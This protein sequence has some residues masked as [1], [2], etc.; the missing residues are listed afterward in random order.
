MD[1]SP[2]AKEEHEAAASFLALPESVLV[3]ILEKL[4]Q[5]DRLSRAALACKAWAAAAAAATTVITLTR[6]SAATAAKF[7]SWLQ[8]HGG[9][10]EAIT[11]PQ[12]HDDRVH[13]HMHVPVP[14]Q[15]KLPA[16]GLAKLKLL[17]LHKCALEFCTNASSSGVQ[18]GSSS[19]GQD[20][21]SFVL[22]ALRSIQLQ[23]CREPLGIMSQLGCPRLKSLHLTFS[24]G[25]HAPP[26]DSK[27]LP[28]AALS[29]LLQRLPELMSLTLANH[30]VTDAALAQLSCLQNLQH[31]TLSCEQ[32][33]PA[34]LT[35]LSSS[36]L[37]SF[38]LISGE[39]VLQE[40]DLPAA[41]WPH[42]KLFRVT[43]HAVQPAVVARLTALERL[44][45]DRC[46]L[47]ASLNTV[48]GCRV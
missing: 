32:V 44:H 48:S 17:H 1:C 25:S 12:T 8:Q 42:L 13:A 2:A 26:A 31:C 35:N 15:L 9:V 36:S 3:N 22:P 43:D 40:R 10:V 28:D 45:L 34:V 24:D 37:T 5:H 47:V 39:G 30:S 18:G 33:T 41:G 20:G 19:G 4:S 11:V 29:A 46:D 14:V 23:S 38:M 21:P 27:Q 6:V 16:G 7:S